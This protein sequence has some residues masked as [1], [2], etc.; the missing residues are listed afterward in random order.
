MSL[1]ETGEKYE[2][3]LNQAM[4]KVLDYDNTDDAISDFLKYVGESLNS[5][6]VYIFEN[7]PN[8]HIF[9]N[10]YEW[11]PGKSNSQKNLLQVLDKKYA[12]FWMDSFNKKEEVFVKDVE[13]LKNLSIEVYKFYTFTKVNNFFL[14]PLY[15]KNIFIGFFGVDNSSL[16]TA[17]EVKYI[18]SKIQTLLLSLL[19]IRNSSTRAQQDAM[20]KSYGALA[21]IYYSMHLV[22]VKDCSYV[23]IKTNT[24]IESSKSKIYRNSFSEQIKSVM[25]KLC[26]EDNL[27]SI[28]A[29]TEL[30]TLQERLGENKTI[31]CEFLGLVTGWCRA[32]FIVVDYDGEGNIAHVIFAV[33]VIDSEKKRENQLVYLSE[34]DQMTSIRNRSSGEERI[35]Q[36]LKNANNGLFCLFDIDKFKKVND[37]YG[38]D[39]GDK[40]L[41]AVAKC[42]SEISRSNDVVMRLGG[43]EFVLFAP[44]LLDRNVAVSYINRLFNKIGNIKIPG[45]E[46]LSITVSLGAVFTGGKTKSTFNEIYKKADKL[47]YKSKK[48]VGFSYSF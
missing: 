19:K 14:F 36:E 21:G 4:V 37:N 17:E 20:M 45:N 33:E 28:L 11:V 40:V 38:H 26:H 48:E 23:E 44:G 34:I 29:F 24:S 15:D 39:I 16:E 9:R 31:V 25:G 7:I 8:E 13:I 1:I 43:D 10:T 46:D 3:I 12:D 2:T 32:R 35:I 42:M 30:S 18:G 47:L 5:S 6:R 27:Q 22:D 41:I